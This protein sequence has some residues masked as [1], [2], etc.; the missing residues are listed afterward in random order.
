MRSSGSPATRSATPVVTPRQRHGADAAAWSVTDVSALQRTAGNRAVSR[1][2]STTVQRQ[3]PPSGGGGAAGA[4]ASGLAVDLA[5]AATFDGQALADEPGWKVNKGECATGLQYVFY[6]AGK[7]LGKT[8]TWKQGPKVR[9][10]SIPPG[11]A[12]ASFRNGKYS[13]DHAAILI[14]ETKDG[15]EVWDQFNNPPKPWGRRTLRFSKNKDRSNN[16]NMFFV[17]QH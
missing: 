8:A 9:G 5:H 11:T 10:N 14:R 15:L 3:A 7:P 16:G 6:K 2:L 12:I 4:A 17:I 13:N 1:V